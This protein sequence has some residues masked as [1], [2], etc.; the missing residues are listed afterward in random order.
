M[1]IIAAGMVAAIGLALAKPAEAIPCQ[2][3]DVKQNGADALACAGAFSG[4]LSNASSFESHLNSLTN[5]DW[6]G[7]DPNPLGGWIFGYKWNDGGA[8]EPGIFTSNPFSGDP[9]TGTWSV[10]LG[11]FA[12]FVLTF[13]QG[14]G[15]A[16]Y[17][18][19]NSG[20]TSGT[21]LIT[22]FKAGPTT[23][24]SWLAV[25]VRGPIARAPEPDTLAL[26]ALGGGFLIA[27]RRLVRR[28]VA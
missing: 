13:K 21:Y 17:Y 16:H 10:D 4:N 14:P 11:G 7:A 25:S 6:L 18:F 22:W 5:A 24:W 12:E 9:D 1:R 19:T 28:R 26:L 23:D 2:L 27:S 8:G 15:F 3:T 20:S